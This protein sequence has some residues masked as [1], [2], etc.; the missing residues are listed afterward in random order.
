MFKSLVDAAIVTV[1]R[2]GHG[3]RVHVNDELQLDFS[4]NHALS[5]YLVAAIRSL[6]KESPTHALDVLTLVESILES[7]EQILMRQKDKIFADKLNELKAQGMPYEE[8]QEVLEK[9]DHPKPLAEFVY[10]TYNEFRLL[11]PWAREDNV[12][13]KSIA[14]D[15]VEQF[16]SFTEYVREYGLQRIEGLLLRYLSD[17]YKTLLTNVPDE[18]KTDEVWDIVD[19]LAAMVKEIDS[20]L[21]DEWEKMRNPDRA[22]EIALRQDG[23]V[24]PAGTQDITADARAFAVLVRNRMFDLVR[25][26]SRGT[27]DEGVERLGEGAGITA[28]D[29]AAGRAL[30]LE[31]ATGALRTDMEARSP[32]HLVIEKEELRWRVKQVLLDDDGPTSVFIEGRVDLESSRAEGRAVVR[33]DRIATG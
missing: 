15:M 24:E 21:L 13:P 17:V 16:L 1:V 30:F 22:L 32:K 26:L 20:S 11:H 9:L 18:E 25:D 3:R 33:I 14:R 5:L 27:F 10:D 29:L 31:N 12:R 23:R 8:R 7:P 28:Q 4:L 19:F 2:D 6:D